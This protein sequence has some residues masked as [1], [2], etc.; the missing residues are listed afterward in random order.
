MPLPEQIWYGAGEVFHFLQN[1]LDG[2]KIYFFNFVYF[3]ILFYFFNLA[4]KLIS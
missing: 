3:F 2:L 4:S 1:N